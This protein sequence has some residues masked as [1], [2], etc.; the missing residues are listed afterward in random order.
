MKEE[1]MQIYFYK[2]Y[3]MQVYF[4]LKEK[5]RNVSSAWYPF[6]IYELYFSININ[7]ISYERWECRELEKQGLETNN[8]LGF[9]EN[10]L[11]KKH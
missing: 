7:L 11:G 9:V 3:L 2:E 6:Q 10:S 8:K 4:V 5:K 1:L